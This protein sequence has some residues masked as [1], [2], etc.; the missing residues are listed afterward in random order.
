SLVSVSRSMILSFPPAGADRRLSCGERV[1]RSSPQ[2]HISRVEALSYG[3]ILVPVEGGGWGQT[4]RSGSAD[5]RI[6]YGGLQK[7]F[8]QQCA[9]Q[10]LCRHDLHQLRHLPA[11]GAPQF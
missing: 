7:T 8:R 10:L 3:G 6:T 4:E 2:L 1:G 11:A 9:G 5:E